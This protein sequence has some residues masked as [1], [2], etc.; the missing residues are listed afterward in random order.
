MN[1]ERPGLP[2]RQLVLHAHKLDYGDAEHV[3]MILSISDMT[4]AR[5]S[6][7]L[8]DDLVREKAILL[9]EL[10]HRVANSLQIIASVLIQS[11]RTSQS[12]E[13]RSH[14]ADAHNRVM[15]VA[16]LQR[17][18]AAST[19]G[20]VQLRQYFGDLCR[21]IGASMIRDHSQLSI[22]VSCDDSVTSADVSVSLG[23]I[24]TE[25]VI[26]GLKHAFPG[27]RKGTITVAYASHQDGWALTVCDDGVGMPADPASSKPGLGTSIV[28]ALAKQLSA[29]IRVRDGKPGTHV[30]VGHD[31]VADTAPPPKLSV[32]A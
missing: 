21:S 31:D 5:R 23:L 28:E 8:K 9:Q 2:T 18:L 22:E 6:D 10:Q 19:L 7:K 17:Q 15:S 1:L 27:N 13:T 32:V 14:L 11:A 24:I 20:D 3:R 29:E 16:S 30:T 25:L 12:D 26:N 4:E